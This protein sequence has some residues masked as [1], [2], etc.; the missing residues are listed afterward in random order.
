MKRSV[1]SQTAKPQV[2]LASPAHAGV[3]HP[4]HA[5]AAAPSGRLAQLADVMNN[6]SKV[7]AM[8]QLGAAV[9]RSPRVQSLFSLVD[10]FH[11]GPPAQLGGAGNFEST[12]TQR[13]AHI[14]APGA[15]QKLGCECNSAPGGHT[16]GP[17]P[18]CTKKKRTARRAPGAKATRQDVLQPKI[19]IGGKD[20]EK[21][22]Y[23][24]LVW[25]H[26]FD[27]E[28]TEMVDRMHNGGQSPDFIFSTM[29]QLNTEIK[30][31]RNAITGM[32][33]VH[34][35]CCAYPDNTH[36]PFL[37]ATYWKSCGTMC[38][39]PYNPFGEASDAI[40]A[41]F[42]P[43]EN[44]R[45]D[46]WTF[47]VAIEYYAMLK[48]IGRDKFNQKFPKGKGLE[49]S[50]RGTTNVQGQGQNF[51]FN[52]YKTVSVSSAKEL[53][54]GDWVYFKNFPDYT[55]VNPGGLWQGENAIYMGNGK[56]QGFGSGLR[57][58][59]EMN[60]KLVEA[61]NDG[62]KNLLDKRKPDSLAL[63]GGGLLLDKVNRPAI[64][65]MT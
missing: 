28:R 32:E 20:L 12:D 10:S 24:D 44:T 6:S 46:C 18:E 51:I 17:C 63:D 43:G 14:A 21:D 19:I 62:V 59:P 39:E 26:V 54:P 34:K 8:A 16:R 31:R 30:V 23:D 27:I 48:G 38:F 58:E 41:I 42:A 40:E 55:I 50:W 47:M 36:P 29:D 61:Y 56:Y 64:S 4:V 65:T 33:E 7:Q 49:I 35:H 45:L 25:K 2:S 9:Q 11:Q 57:T 1:P 22:A 3:R 15:K 5:A 13:P 53:V 37:N 60:K 52:N